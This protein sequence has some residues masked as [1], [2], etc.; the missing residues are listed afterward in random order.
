MVLPHF[1]KLQKP[2][3]LVQKP[4]PVPSTPHSLRLEIL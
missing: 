3:G 4:G 2:I 1:L